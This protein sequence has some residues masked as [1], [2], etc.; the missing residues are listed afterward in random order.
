MPVSVLELNIAPT[1]S[2]TCSL[3]KPESAANTKSDPS[4]FSTKP[5][6]PSASAEGLPEASPT[7]IAPLAKLAIFAVVTA[8][9]AIFAVVTFESAIFA[10]V[11][12]AFSIFAVVTASLAISPAAIVPSSIWSDVICPSSICLVRILFCAI[13]AEVTELVAN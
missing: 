3:D 6:D 11:T 1:M 12:F 5:F 9:S 8:S 10:V 2:C 4:D 7:S 13:F